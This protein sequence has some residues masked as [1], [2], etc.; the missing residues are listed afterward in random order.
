MH[1]KATALLVHSAVRPKLLFITKNKQSCEVHVQKNIEINKTSMFKAIII[2]RI[3][4]TLKCWQ[5][6]TIFW[7]SF[8]LVNHPSQNILILNKKTRFG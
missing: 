4:C 7:F 8:M 5:S 6:T 2:V 3:C 1:L